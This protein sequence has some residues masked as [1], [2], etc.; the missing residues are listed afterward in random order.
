MLSRA[1]G[2]TSKVYISGLAEG[3]NESEIE[4]VFRNFGRVKQVWVARQLPGIA[5]VYFDDERNAQMAIKSLDGA[6]VTFK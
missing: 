5:V 3:A 1:A 6:L 2:T 4:S